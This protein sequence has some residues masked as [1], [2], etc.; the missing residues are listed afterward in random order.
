MEHPRLSSSTL[1]SVSCAVLIL[2]VALTRLFSFITWYH[3]TYLVV[4]LALLG[5]GAAGTYLAIRT[6]L[7]RADYSHTIGYSCVLFSLLTIAAVAASVWLPVGAEGFFEGKYKLLVLIVLTHLVLAIPFFLAGTAIGFVLM[8]NRDQT[9]RLYSADL[10]GAGVGSFFAVVLL[11]YLGSISAIFLAA[12]LPALVALAAFWKGRPGLKIGVA[13]IVLLLAGGTVLNLRHEVIPLKITP[14]KELQQDQVIFTKWNILNRIDV[15]QPRPTRFHFGGKISEAYHGPP[16]LVLPIYQDG[17]AP[18]ALV[19][20]GSEPRDCPLFSYYLQS[21]PYAIRPGPQRV[22]VIGI[23]GGIDALIAEHA[24]AGHIVGVDINPTMVELLSRRYRGFAADLFHDRNLE[25]VVSEGRH[26]LTKTSARFDVIQLSGVDT[27]AALSGGSFVLSESYLY[28]TEAVE[29]LL[30]HLNEGGVLSYSRWLFTPPRESLKL[31][32]TECE[33]LRRLG[34]K[35]PRKHFLIVAGGPVE[36]RWADT[37]VKRTP[38]ASQEIL[39]LRSWARDKQFD[40]IY[41]P[42]EAHPNFFNTYL[43]A[44]EQEQK[45]FVQSYAYDISPS[46]DDQPFFFQFYRWKNALHP[47]RAQGEGGYRVVKMPKGLLSLTVALAELSSLSVVLVLMPLATR[48]ALGL[49]IRQS[50]SWLALFAGLGVGFIVAEMVLIQKLS[51]FLGGPAYSMAITLC[52]LLVSSGLGSWL[53]QGFSRSGYRAAAGMVVGVLLV[54]ALE[55]VFLDWGVPALLGFAH[56]WRCAIAVIAIAP[57]G[58]LMG[59]PFPTLLAKS[60]ETS[61]T[62]PPWAWGVNACA[63]V[64]GSVLATIS[65]ITMGF[66]HTWLLAMSMYFGVLLIVVSRLPRE[67]TPTIRGDFAGRDN[68]SRHS[69]KDAVRDVRKWT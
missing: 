46:H 58:L 57:L 10:L 7:A 15:T 18:T 66:N 5:Y 28:T 31:V 21:A 67:Q 13:V 36:G 22:L 16:P 54:Q 47:R 44:S 55:L 23:G 29:D 68:L 40:L 45:A 64:L 37:I 14:E 12:A 60:G 8:R 39:A 56:S 34:V 49:R 24:G 20:V 27:F 19:H 61:G 30:N 35:D 25:L 42:S 11:N 3:L 32:A 33:A 6:D 38:F 50:V 43:N 59:M 52:G 65:S 63:T 53:S 4:S 48:K 69:R 17:T 62:L 26:Y 2:E 9:N 51:V 1:F 41:D